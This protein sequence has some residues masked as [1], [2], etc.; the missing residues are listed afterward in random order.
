MPEPIAGSTASSTT[1]DAQAYPSLHA[2]LV[3]ELEAAGVNTAEAAVAEDDGLDYSSDMEVADP[4]FVD[5]EDGEFK[6][7]WC[8]ETRILEHRENERI[9]RCS[10]PVRQ[11]T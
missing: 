11:C 3:S 8:P 9:E 5:P 7:P 2:R 10:T 1:S 4:G 6:R